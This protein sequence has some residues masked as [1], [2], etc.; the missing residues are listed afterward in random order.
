MRFNNFPL[1]N[2][3]S[4]MNRHAIE[5]RLPKPMRHELE[6]KFGA[7]L[8]NIRILESHA[9]TL[10]N[11]ASFVNGNDIHFAP[12]RFDPHTAEGQRLIGHEVAHVVQ[13]RGGHIAAL[14]S[15][16]I[17]EFANSNDSDAND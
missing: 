12:G 10:Q 11:A 14:A 15:P 3:Q 2:M 13:Q 4:N 7:D 9:P 5:S 8:S 16:A 6:K 17:A 1:G